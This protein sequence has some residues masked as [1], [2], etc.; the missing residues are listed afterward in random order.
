MMEFLG[1]FMDG[2]IDREAVSIGLLLAAFGG[3][4]GMIGLSASPMW[5]YGVYGPIVAL[6][7]GIAIFVVGVAL[8]VWAIFH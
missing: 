7:L 3:V 2:V 8:C 6:A 1:R 4:L 5:R